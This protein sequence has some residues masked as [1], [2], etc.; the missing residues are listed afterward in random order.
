MVTAKSQHQLA[1]LYGFGQEGDGVL[2]IVKFH[3]I[4]ALA[5]IQRKEAVGIQCSIAVAVQVKRQHALAGIDPVAGEIIN[6]R[7]AGDQDLIQSTGI[8]IFNNA[9]DAGFIHGFLLII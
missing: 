3:K 4:D 1:L 2:G 9:I 6:G 7:G 8:H 5:A